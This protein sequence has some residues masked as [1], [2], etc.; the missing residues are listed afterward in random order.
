[1]FIILKV[2]VLK[3]ENPLPFPAVGVSEKSLLGSFTLFL[4]PCRFA[5]STGHDE[6]K[7]RGRACESH[8]RLRSVSSLLN[9]KTSEEILAQGESQRQVE[10]GAERTSVTSECVSSRAQRGNS[11]AIPVRDLS[12]MRS[13]GLLEGSLTCVRDDKQFGERSPFSEYRS[14]AFFS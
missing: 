5:A 3:K 14:S 2:N 13:V 8:K 1:M 9:R 4:F 12:V 11:Q 6:R 10:M 7:N